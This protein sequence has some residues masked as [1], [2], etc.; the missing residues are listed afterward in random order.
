MR[1]EMCCF[2]VER[3]EFGP[4]TAYADHVLTIDRGEMTALIA[5]DPRLASVDIALANPGERVRIANIVEMTEPR[6][7]GTADHYYPGMLGPLYRAGDGQTHALKGA[8]IFEMHAV[9]G[10][11]GSVV[12]MAGVGA[13][14]TPHGKT[15]NVCLLAFPAPGVPLPDYCRALKHAGL[16]ASVYLAKT[17]RGMKADEVEVFDLERPPGSLAGLPRVAYLMQLH[18]HG[19]M[20]EPFVYGA[21]TRSYYP[22]VLH[23]NE[24]LDGAIVCGHYNI[25]SALKNS[26]YTL[27]N[28]PVIRGLLRRHGTE[29]TSGAS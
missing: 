14:L 25:S 7:K 15:A 16:A 8:A 2:D 12:D 3:V 13:T 27:L 4:E 20:R 19:E 17:T 28:H 1:L 18:S 9:A 5:A 24:I 23:P 22:T 21:N 6:V 11:N 10:L 29:S 26:T